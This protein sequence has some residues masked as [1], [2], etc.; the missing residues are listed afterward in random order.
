MAPGS[1]HKRKRP[2][3]GTSYDEGTSR[4]SPHRPESMGIAQHGER[5]R[6]RG[7]NRRQS[8][9]GHQSPTRGP[10]SGTAAGR[11][12]P[13]PQQA[14]VP[15]TADTPKNDSSRPSTPAQKEPTEPSPPFAYEYL[16]DERLG[17]WQSAGREAVLGM[18]EDLDAID[19]SILLQEIVRAA[20]DG[21]LD[22]SEAGRTIASIIEASDL[23]MTSILLDSIPLLSSGEYEKP[24]LRHLI[25]ATAI[26]PDT[27]RAEM[28][29][30]PLIAL[31]LV[32]STFGRVKTRKGTVILYKQAN[33][34][35]LREESE[36]YAK[37]IT[38][39]FNTAQS[40]MLKDTDPDMAVASFERVKALVG[41]FDLDVGR[42]LD[43]TLDVSANLLVR[44][45]QF[46]L[47]FY[48]CSSWWPGTPDDAAGFAIES[49][50]PIG[51]QRLPSWAVPGSHS[52][53]SAEWKEQH[54][55]EMSH[56]RETRDRDFWGQVNDYGLDAFFQL[57]ARRIAQFDEVKE[58]LEQELL[59]EV[60]SNRQE[61][62]AD[63]RKRINESRKLMLETQCMPPPGNPDAAQ[64]LG[65]KLRFYAS[66]AR[67]AT[68]VLPENLVALA[69]LLIKI[70][71]ISLRDLYPHLYP[72]DEAMP[73]ERD[74]LEREKA[75]RERMGRP[76]AGGNALAMAGALA[77]D[78]IPAVKTLKSEL[79]SGGS[80]PKPE[81]K[82]E[83]IKDEL[84]PPDN[85]KV[86]MLR[87]LLLIGAMP[88]A[89]FILGRFPWLPELDPTIPP[90]LHR[91][92][93]H[94]LTRVSAPFE[95]LQDRPALIQSKSSPIDT[96][97]KLDG[98]LKAAPRPIKR[99]VRWM[100]A[101]NADENTVFYYSDWADDIPLC[102]TEDDVFLLCN[103]LLGYLG[104]KVGQDNLL[105]SRLI[106]LAKRSLD[107]DFSDTNRTRWLELMRRLLVP[108]LTLSRH[109]PGIT[110]ELYDLLLLFPTTVRF[111]IYAEWYTGKTSRLLDMRSA[112][113][114]NKYEVKDVLRRV[115]NE[116]GKQQ[117]RALAK[118]SQSSP[119]IVM[120]M[121]IEQLESYSN[122]IPSLVECM[123]YFSLLSYDVLTWSLINNLSGQ[124]R[125]T[126]Q[127]DGML[128]SSWLQALS[129]FVASL[130]T[131][132]STVN[133]VPVIQYIASELRRGN[134]ND[135]EVF[136]QILGEMAGIKAD[137][138]FNDAQVLAMAG[139]E[140]LQLQTVAQMGDNRTTKK[141]QAKRLM[142]SL[143]EC[144]LAGQILIS[145]AQERSTYAD[146]EDNKYMPLKVL[147]NNLDKIQNVYNQYFEV[148]RH[149]LGTDEYTQY[150]PGVLDLVCKYGIDPGVA[151]AACRHVL[152][153]QIAELDEQKKKAKQEEKKRRTSQGKESAADVEMVNGDAPTLQPREETDE[154]APLEDSKTLAAADDA[155]EKA[156]A[157]K[158]PWH[159]VLEPIIVGLSEA[160]PHLLQSTS[161]PFLVTFW[162]LTQ[163]DILVHT[164]SYEQ[165]MKKLNS[166]IKE[167]NND[168]TDLT[169]AAA[170]ERDR[171]KKALLSTVDDLSKEMK[172]RIAA[173]TKIRNRLTA[174]KGHWFERSTD[175]EDLDKRHIGLLQE[176]FLPRSIL[177]PL[178]AHFCFLMLKVLHNSGTPGFSTMHLLHQFFKKQQLVAFM[179]QCTATE[180]Q[181]FGR[182]LRDT[183]ALLQH[184]HA[185][186]ATYEKEAF[187]SKKQF[188][189]FAKKL[190]ANGTPEVL[191]EFEDFRRL[192]YNWH[193][194]LNGA[195]KLCFDSGE[196]MHIRNGFI[197]LRAV[198]GVFPSVNFMGRDMLSHVEKMSK[199]EAR[200][201]LKLAASSLIGPLKQREKNWVMPQ[202]FRL[203]DPGKEATK[204]SGSRAG[205]ARPETPNTQ[206]KDSVP[207]LNAQAAE[208]KPKI[209]DQAVG[210]LGDRKE[211]LAGPEEGEVEDIKMVDTRFEDAN[212]STTTDQAYPTHA[213]SSTPSAVEKMAVK[214][215][216][217]KSS[218]PA[219]VAGR[220]PTPAS[221]PSKPPP[222][223]TSRAESNRLPPGLPS[224]PE[225][226]A[227]R[228]GNRERTDVRHPGRSEDRYGR[229]DRPG[230]MPP[231]RERSPVGRSSRNRT[232]E[233]DPYYGSVP[234]RSDVRGPQ[235][236]RDER[237]PSRPSME[238]RSSR[239]EPRSSRREPLPPQESLHL[240]PLP[241]DNRNH[242]NGQSSSVSSTSTPVDYRSSP[243]GTQPIKAPAGEGVGINPARLA[244][245]EKQENG[246]GR[247]REPPSKERDNT[248]YGPPR[249]DER[250]AHD[251]VR[252][253]QSLST[254]SAFEEDVARTRRHESEMGPPT[255]P[256]DM[257]YG[258]LNGP[259]DAPPVGP[260]QSNGAPGVRGR[261]FSTPLHPIS[262]RSNE[263]L[264]LP[265]TSQP[266]DS[267]ASFR[268]SRHG[269]RE[270]RPS[271][272]RQHSANSVPTTPSGEVNS[273]AGM[274]P[275]RAAALSTGPQSS[276]TNV[277]QGGGYGATQSPT[278]PPSGPRA[279]NRPPAGTPSGPSPVNSQPP[280]G[281]GGRRTGQAAE[282]QRAN[283]NAQ[284]QGSGN[285]APSPTSQGISFRGASNRQSNTGPS[286]PG[287][288]QPPQSVASAIE[289]PP[290]VAPP[291]DLFGR[292]GP[293]DE[294]GP[295]GDRRS[296]YN[297]PERP[298]SRNQVHD[299]R[300]D[301]DASRRTMPGP[302]EDQWQ[303][304][305]GP[306][307][308]RRP[309]RG[310]DSRDQRPPGPP[311][312]DDV[313]PRRPPPGTVQSNSF[314]PPPLPPPPA[315][316]ES[317]QA[318]RGPDEGRRGGLRGEGRGG[319]AQGPRDDGMP[320]GR[321]RR[322]EDGPMD[323]SK[324]RRSGR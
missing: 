279:S 98:Y 30:E 17:T 309:P 223:E 153:S 138:V 240:R 242:Q 269:R 192:L 29:V 200:Q 222:R 187:G 275:T 118:V 48:R 209:E 122:M 203:N 90:L 177:S 319:R 170:K 35:L 175:R 95:G 265:S 32:R 263:P 54:A 314:A 113:D 105:Y 286:P 1:A 156:V 12:H 51:F 7:G 100:H 172:G 207:P 38:E 179:F 205:S 65:F 212:P 154:T 67:D 191:L 274:H 199:K 291:Q 318:P 219:P 139:G 155:D 103:T 307:G 288:S 310:G 252:T 20:L 238:P 78:T 87:S 243:G 72:P 27:I 220:T 149:N 82:D 143:I 111:N 106:R 137:I 239:D 47:K 227:G 97:A 93:N 33:F 250:R 101:D 152:A 130:F 324:R 308:D 305:G 109:N 145:I 150:V 276:Q 31:G 281:P 80:T 161:V 197:V 194:F 36:G 253:E 231:S 302:V 163:Q 42:V 157:E 272:D 129:N 268:G 136:E 254:L 66:A 91:I 147:G 306:R 208:F 53:D 296:R 85:Q 46:F 124:G 142:K 283:I 56:I 28:D 198:V 313:P 321:K 99:A 245:I 297:E 323:E 132:H 174:E 256:Q 248:R 64:L 213:S 322:H 316:W 133:I 23:D 189:G 19:G 186:K 39:Y 115:T 94:M 116:S 210:T 255:A 148:L 34:N 10:Q 182:F 63:K 196:Y 6:G 278:A 123:R 114:R 71:F 119:G 261:N 215:A 251:Q 43:I 180:A 24:A 270:S 127:A 92:A 289:P 59:P 301:D 112:F 235:T 49:I 202:A 134:S 298:D 233:R 257:A 41:A 181:N 201:D 75:D 120:K 303:G 226:P 280:S 221:I 40:A 294:S 79:K 144:G 284:L 232:P 16:T 18:C 158:T 76:G 295:R 211:S 110:Q 217:S 159:P 287:A 230:D 4:P 244:L 267:P 260:R 195:I 300:I 247:R 290:R 262:T 83:P 171:K 135:L 84:P 44:A 168:R 8:R 88:E 311:R 229:L 185:D 69:A 128:T 45:F 140:L 167:I 183:L 9:Q 299:R 218:T 176:C 126:R 166:Q 96:V 37:L 206:G 264:P 81:M 312:A 173:Y 131:R 282:R 271:I 107:N 258:R 178:D 315:D 50:Q 52:W 3:R 102:Q 292:N 22:A 11:R 89:L 241:T 70:G 86:I 21:R 214:Q 164:E 169:S 141:S 2:D 108:A 225:G 55:S 304:R 26:D 15:T 104:V 234:P 160:L 62:N 246:S 266:P 74:R 77:D 320:G 259:P 61:T 117:A 249:F 121:V 146:K 125:G 277:A 162:T 60:G 165:E 273:V 188:P 204:P 190:D 216:E 58:S 57:G 5:G 236:L 25:Q 293:M 237:P 13:S 317:R 151:L 193:S 184:W 73:A 228:G 285:G 14:R 68:D 224:K